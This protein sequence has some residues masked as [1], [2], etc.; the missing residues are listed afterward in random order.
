MADPNKSKALAGHEE[1][2]KGAE[3]EV[4]SATQP[5]V[6]KLNEWSTLA[7]NMLPNAVVALVVFVVTMLLTR[8]LTRPSR[9][10]IRRFTHN[11]QV[12]SLGSIVL[13][14][15]FLLGGLFIALTVLHLDKT[16]TS[17]L[18]GVGVLG[19]ALGF[20]FQDGAANLLAGVILSVSRY[21]F[22]NGDVI[23]TND[24]M[25]RVEKLEL[26]ATSLRQFTGELV[27]I[28]N[29]DV[30]QKPLINF[31]EAGQ[32]RVDLEVGVAYESDLDLVRAV[33]LEAIAAVS[34]RVE[35]KEPEVLFTGFGGS[36]ID[37]VA[38]LWILYDA[39]H[40]YFRARSTM[41]EN[42]TKAYRVHG[43]TIPFPIRTL[44]PGGTKDAWRERV[45][46]D[47]DER[48]AA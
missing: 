26:R 16:V 18:A 41:V 35:D 5:I 43:I 48:G 13:R 45:I 6:D 28:P 47:V 17:L 12:I 23:K 31:S 4:L 40:D 15:S 20:A 38:R 46:A 7:I 14:L 21:P 9:W 3:I 39:Q 19:I 27:F 25:G 24:Y 44:V 29:K 8:L 32:R 42:I 1:L 22:I 10:V 37:L 36:S 2:V 30:L 33:T 11:E 34:G